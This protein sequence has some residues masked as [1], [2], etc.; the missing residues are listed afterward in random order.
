RAAIK[1]NIA[2]IAAHTNWDIVE[3]GVN[4]ELAKLISL[5]NIRALDL[6]S[7]LGACGVLSGALDY[8]EFLNRVK[9]AWGLSYIDYYKA[10][11]NKILRVALCGGSGAE[12]W[13]LAK[14][15]EADVYLTADM[16]YH[17]LIDANK[18]GLNI[19]LMEHGEMER[20]SLPELIRKLKNICGDEIEFKLLDV[21]ALVKRESF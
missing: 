17:E 5:N 16:K 9:A 8:K 2:V 15:F 14:N 19:A 11:N 6:E 13:P 3:G 21:K 20:A 1:N 18:S 4:T 10:N 12:F 7:G